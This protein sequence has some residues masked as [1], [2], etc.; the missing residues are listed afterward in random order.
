MRVYICDYLYLA[1]LT[2][3]HSLKHQTNSCNIKKDATVVQET[4]FRNDDKEVLHGI[5]LKLTVTKQEKQGSGSSRSFEIGK[6][7]AA[8]ILCE[9]E[10]GQNLH[11]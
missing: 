4:R 5:L 2:K 3:W 9:V 10:A 8:W 6:Q 7:F 1:T 11:Q